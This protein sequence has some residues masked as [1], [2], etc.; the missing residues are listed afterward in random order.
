MLQFNQDCTEKVRGDLEKKLPL[1]DKRFDSVT[2]VFVMNYVKN[3]KLLLKEI[4]RVLKKKSI[5]VAVL[6]G[7]E[8]NSWQKQ[9]EIN[10]FSGKEWKK[11]LEENGFKVK[12][13]VL[14]GVW[15]FRCEIK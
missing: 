13:Y 14:K 8:I 5:F 9:K 10:S 6:S 2:A 7:L 11:I 12:F 3:Y 15:F 4:K 1:A